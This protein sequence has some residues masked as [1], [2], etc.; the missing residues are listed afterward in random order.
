MKINIRCIIIILLFG[1]YQIPNNA[2]HDQNKPHFTFDVI[3][4]IPAPGSNC[5]GLTWDGEYLWVSEIMKDSIYKIDT[6]DGN[7]IHKIPTSPANHLFEGL[8]WDGEY[9]WA[10]HYKSM[11]I[12]EPTIS[13]IDPVTG[14]VLNAAT[15][16]VYNSW[17]HGIA[18]DGEYIWESDFRHHK[19][20]KI[21]QNNGSALDSIV[22]PGDESNIGLT[23]YNGFLI[24]NDTNTDSI[25]QIDPLTKQVVNKWFCPYT[26]ARDM[27]F[28]GECFWFIAREVNLIYKI[29]II[30]SDV[31]NDISTQINNYDLAQNY[32][33]PFN[34][35]TKIRWQVPV[36]SWQTIK[37]FDVLGKEIATLV[38][39]YKE[40]GKHEIEFSIKSVMNGNGKE[41][42]SGIYFYQLS[43]GN[44]LETKKMMI[45][46]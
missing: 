22:A 1:L 39:D 12:T 13:R 40:A 15:I 44:Y 31:D 16:Q 10:S 26:N 42:S 29:K 19:I 45:L 20:Y 43:A 24:S 32:P 7:I 6:T 3:K 27:E 23:W 34:P 25:Y 37:V 28:D 46:K 35:S 30:I 8:A 41:I 4:T 11:Y 5:Q 14:N 38:D 18:W 17:P 21:N 36:S 2:Q 33:N 9:L